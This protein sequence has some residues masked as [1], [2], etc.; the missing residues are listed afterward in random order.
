MFWGGHADR[1]MRGVSSGSG[2]LCEERRERAA[3]AFEGC[4][5]HGEQ[6]TG[7]WG[8]KRPGDAGGGAVAS[9]QPDGTAAAGAYGAGG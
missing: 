4:P 9:A 7:L 3:I 2:G 8:S 6:G 5:S 1:T